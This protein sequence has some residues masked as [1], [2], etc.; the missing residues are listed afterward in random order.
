MPLGDDTLSFRARALAQ[1][2][3]LSPAAKSLIDRISRE[4]AESQPLPEF[5]PWAA[6]AMLAG[7]CLR[8]VEE[9][10]AGHD[11]SGA[12][13]VDAASLDALD[14]SADGVA[15][16]LRNGDEATVVL[17]D[18]DEVITTLD[19]L[20]AS[21]IERRVD[22]WR[23][24]VGADSWRMFEDYIAHWTVKGYAIRTA[25]PTVAADR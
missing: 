15:E 17:A 10:R 11:A 19:G 8:T 9:D 12:V 1:A 14:S 3:P 7:Y 13:S 22:P 16:A 21:E 4:E 18:V 6:S 25:E 20:I 23:E 24:E 5:G 2:H